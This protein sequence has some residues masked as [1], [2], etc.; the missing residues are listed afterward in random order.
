[1]TDLKRTRQCRVAAVALMA[2][3]VAPAASADGLVN[4]GIC[5]DEGKDTDAH[6]Q[7]RALSLQLR[8]VVPTLEEHA[9]VDLFGEV[10]E[11][12]VDEWLASEE[13]ADRVV[14]LHRSLLWNNVSN[15]NLFNAQSGLTRIRTT[16]AD[17]YRYWRRQVSIRYRGDLVPCLDQPAEWDSNGQII[18]Y[19]QADGTNAEGWVEVAPY[20]APDTTIRVCAFDAQHDALSPTGT[21]CDTTDGYEDVACGCGPGLAWC[22]YGG[23]TTRA[24]VEAMAEDVDRRVKANLL[25]DGSYLD[26][27]R[28][29]RAFVNGPLV[30]YLTYQTGVPAGTRVTPDPYPELPLPDLAWTDADTWVEIELGAEHAGI[31]TSPAFLLRFQTNRARANR[32]YSAFMCQPFQPPD[33]GIP[34][35]DPDA[36]PS[37]DLQIQDGCKY[38]HALLEPA[39]SHWSRWTESGAGYLAEDAFPSFDEDCQ[40]CATTGESCSQ[41]CRRYYITTA[42][43]SEEVPW[44][45]WM[46]SYEFRRS[47]HMDFPD[48]GPSRLALQSTVDGRMPECVAETAAAWLLGRQL[49][50]DEDGYIEGLASQFQGADFSYRELVKAIVTSDTW[51]RVQ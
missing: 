34:T 37:L 13:F 46:K 44:F 28:G 30:H 49:L 50:P 17:P 5:Q 51:R 15:V 29:R 16:S 14:R 35:G 12:L 31:L 3:F 40:R 22:R 1:M 20:W 21:R 43:T 48:A 10:P 11:S 32:F 9:V 4:E 2:L 26:L 33:S 38:C 41:E 19:P 7:L 39:A 45:G 47:E 27:F 42:V 25:E 23:T 6:R 36:V 18:T 8:G 24:P